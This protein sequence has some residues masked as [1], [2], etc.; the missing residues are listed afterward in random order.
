MFVSCIVQSN[1]S[2]LAVVAVIIIT[3]QVVTAILFLLQNFD[4]I[5]Q[6]LNQNEKKNVVY[7][8]PAQ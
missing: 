6:K 7:N 5:G 8:L 2:N 1:S 3:F 4:F